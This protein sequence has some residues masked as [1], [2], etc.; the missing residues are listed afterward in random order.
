MSVKAMKP[1][2]MSLHEISSFV[3]LGCSA[4]ERIHPQ[5]I[6]IHLDLF[7]AVTPLACK[8][9]QLSDTVCYAKITNNIIQACKGQHFQTVE[10]LAQHCFRTIREIIDREIKM[11]LIVTKVRPPVSALQG[12]VSFCLGDGID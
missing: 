10:Y 7:F 3:H 8:T 11:R 2:Q 4:E 12:G 6:R 5:E 9:D 1:N